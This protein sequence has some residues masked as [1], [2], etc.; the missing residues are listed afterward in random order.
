MLNRDN[1]ILEILLGM[2]KDLKEVQSE[3][4]HL[5]SM[6]RMCDKLLKN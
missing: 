1:K 6:F 3:V 4:K 2:Q 5:Y